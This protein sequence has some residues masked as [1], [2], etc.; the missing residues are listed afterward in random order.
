MAE[1]K[2]QL[3]GIILTLMVFGAISITIAHVYVTSAAKVSTY[4][5][6]L[7]EP[8]ADEVGYTIPTNGAVVR[9]DLV[10]FPGLSY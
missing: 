3:L 5:T 10:Q 9:N 1:I 6:D 4:S 8:A 7:E 2:G